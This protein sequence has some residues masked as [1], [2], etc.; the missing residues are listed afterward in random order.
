MDGTIQVDLT[1]KDEEYARR[2]FAGH[3]GWKTRLVTEITR[4]SDLLS[5]SYHWDTLQTLK[6]DMFALNKHMDVLRYV[7]QWLEDEG[8]DNSHTFMDG[9]TEIKTEVAKVIGV[10]N[11]V[12]HTSRPAPTP[13][14]APP[15]GAA[16]GAQ[17]PIAADF[18]LKIAGT[19]KPKKLRA[20]DTPQQFHAWEERLQAYFTTGGLDK[21]NIAS[22][23]AVARA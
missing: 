8:Y 18:A 14:I 4:S 11:E 2:K 9:L 16:A 6:K 22:Q 12:I 7:A 10:S 1:G 19:L 3:K 23:Q 17:G 20:T 13:I 15:A 21:I 5:Q